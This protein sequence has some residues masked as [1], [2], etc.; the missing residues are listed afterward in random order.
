MVENERLVGEAGLHLRKA[1]LERLL[2]LRG[3]ASSLRTS[4]RFGGGGLG[5]GHGAVGLRVACSQARWR[6]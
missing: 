2:C 3:R 4:R 6:R 5:R 1:P